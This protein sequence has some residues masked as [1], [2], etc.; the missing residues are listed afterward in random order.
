MPRPRCS[1]FIA[2]LVGATLALAACGDDDDG[3]ATTT[4]SVTEDTTTTTTAAPAANVIE[5]E[6]NGGAVVGGVRT[7]DVA[8]GEDVTIRVTADIEDEVHVHGYDLITDTVPG[9]PVE[10]TFTADIPG[11]FEVE[12]EDL[13]LPIAE[14]R[15]S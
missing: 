6:V 13:G 14:L 12:L 8:L 11:Q 15:V 4:T 3:D 7:H 2:V 10:I 5:I 1:S 9:E